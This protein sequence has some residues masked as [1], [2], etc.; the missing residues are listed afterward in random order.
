MYAQKHFATGKR[1]TAIARV[2]MAPGE[3]KFVVNDRQLE[4]YFAGMS[5]QIASIKQ[6]LEMT[7]TVGKYDIYA[8]VM[9]GGMTGQADAVRHGIAKT[10]LTIDPATRAVL[11]KALMLTRDARK[12]ERKKYG[13]KGARKRF[14]YS[15]R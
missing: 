6:P 5:A 10:L 9:G 11:K 13:Q 1:K 2:R 3:G 14:Q 12:K 8:K 15:K 4:D 7:D